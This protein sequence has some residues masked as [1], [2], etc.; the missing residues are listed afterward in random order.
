MKIYKF[1]NEVFTEVN[2]DVI[3]TQTNI[4]WANHFVDNSYLYVGGDLAVYKYRLIDD[5]FILQNNDITVID[6]T[7]YV[8]DS[9]KSL[10]RL[11]FGDSVDYECYGLTKNVVYDNIFLN[12]EPEV[13]YSVKQDN[14]EKDYINI[15]NIL[16]VNNQVYNEDVVVHYGYRVERPDV[17]VGIIPIFGIIGILISIVWLFKRR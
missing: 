1:Q 4:L 10:T 9:D 15:G 11:A 17:F 12:N 16:T 2:Y 8:I 5:E 3:P 7:V 6:P 14:I 13:I